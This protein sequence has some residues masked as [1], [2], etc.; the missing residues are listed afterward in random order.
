MNVEML[1]ENINLSYA[2]TVQGLGGGGGGDGGGFGVLLTQHLMS[3]FPGQ[4][5]AWNFPPEQPLFLTLR[6][7]PDP[8]DGTLQVIFTQHYLEKSADIRQMCI[9]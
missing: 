4:N 6:Q 1:S 8:A 5:P 3:V 2:A 9:R 7:Y